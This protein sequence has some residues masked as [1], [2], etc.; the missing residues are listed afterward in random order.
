MKEL[1]AGRSLFLLFSTFFKIAL[2]VVGGGLAMLPVIEDVFVRKYKLLSSEDMLD[3]IVITQTVPGLIAVNS[4]V[5]VGNKVAGFLGAL[6]AL[7]GVLIPSVV[8]IMIIAAFFPYLDSQNPLV[9]AVFGGIRACIS[10]V[11]IVTACRLFSRVIHNPIDFVLS[12]LFLTGIL[13]NVSPAL[14]ILC[15]MPIGCLYVFILR[16]KQ[17]TLTPDSE[18]KEA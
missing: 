14:I 11:F 12:F 17:A 2:F 1:P 3:M 5:F 18:K 8:I 6:V 9:Q 13:C 7:I 15:A 10:G 4:A 16:K